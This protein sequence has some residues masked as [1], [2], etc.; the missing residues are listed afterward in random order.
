MLRTATSTPAGPANGRNGGHGSRSSRTEPSTSGT[1]T[2]WSAATRQSAARRLTAVVEPARVIDAR[3]IRSVAGLSLTTRNRQHVECER[4][5]IVPGGAPVGSDRRFLALAPH[6][7]DA[8]NRDGRTAGRLRE[9]AASCLR[10][11]AWPAAAAVGWLL[12]TGRRLASH[13]DDFELPILCHRVLV[14]LPQVPLIHEDVDAWRQ[15]VR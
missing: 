8:A 6:S 14:L 7:H 1:A 11:S 9:G 5:L 15:H 3:R 10:G 13:G 4:P 2:A 12:K